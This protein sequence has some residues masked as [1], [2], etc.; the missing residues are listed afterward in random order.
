MRAAMR[1]S[2]MSGSVTAMRCTR[3]FCGSARRDTKIAKATALP[4]ARAS[5]GRLRAAQ[6]G[7][8]RKR[9]PSV[10]GAASIAA[11]ATPLTT[12]CTW[13]C[14]GSPVNPG[15]VSSRWSR[16]NTPRAMVAAP[17]TMISGGPTERGLMTRPSP[18]PNTIEV[19]PSTTKPAI[20][21][22][23]SLA[24]SAA[25]PLSCSSAAG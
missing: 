14:H 9:R 11:Y 2:A 7:A 6:S 19:T 3:P 20:M 5:T 25:R 12:S 10:T 15:D 23:G 22:C 1:A 21:I 13:L 24:S 17:A 4:S 8:W 16:R 18:A